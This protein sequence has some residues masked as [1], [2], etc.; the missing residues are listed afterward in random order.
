MSIL[1]KSTTET[2]AKPGIR[3]EAPAVHVEALLRILQDTDDALTPLTKRGMDGRT[4]SILKEIEKSGAIEVRTEGDS[5]WIDV[6]DRKRALSVIDR[7]IAA[8]RKP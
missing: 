5:V 8:V 6:I 1:P 2:S 3:S 7:L 4:A